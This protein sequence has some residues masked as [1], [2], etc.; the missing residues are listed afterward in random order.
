MVAAGGSTHLSW[1]HVVIGTRS[2]FAWSK[3]CNLKEKAEL[4]LGRLSVRCLDGQRLQLLFEAGDLAAR[5]LLAG[6][7]LLQLLPVPSSV[8]RCSR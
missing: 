8:A 3:A 2:S 6:L 7:Q 4:P 1:G 5:L